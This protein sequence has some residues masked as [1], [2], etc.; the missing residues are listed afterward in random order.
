MRNNDKQKI[1]N[2]FREYDLKIKEIESEMI[3]KQTKRNIA[4]TSNVFAL[5]I[6]CY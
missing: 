5:R 1:D 2:V 6:Y 3:A 4:N